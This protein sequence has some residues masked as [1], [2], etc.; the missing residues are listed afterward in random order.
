MILFALSLKGPPHFFCKIRHFHYY[1]FAFAFV[2]ATHCSAISSRLLTVPWTCKERRPALR[3]VASSWMRKTL[4][5]FVNKNR[6]SKQIFLLHQRAH[7]RAEKKKGRHFYRGSNHLVRKWAGL[8][9]PSLSLCFTRRCKYPSWSKSPL[10]KIHL[11][12]NPFECTN[13]I[14]NHHTAGVTGLGNALIWNVMYLRDI[15]VFCTTD[16]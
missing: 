3:G 15:L 6:N 14:L 1:Y 16:V 13:L 7:P 10:V 5:N 12:Q 9:A 4:K 11:G 2:I 8:G